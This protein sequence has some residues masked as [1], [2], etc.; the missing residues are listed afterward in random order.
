M[1]SISLRQH[2]ISISFSF[3]PL[4]FINI[5]ILINHSSLPLW[6]SINPIPIIPIIIFEEESASAMFL[7][8]KPITRILPPQL[9]CIQSP[10]RPLSMFLI[11]SPHSLILIPILIELNPKPLLAIIPPISNV[12]RWASPL[13]SLNTAILLSGFFLDPVDTSMGTIFLGFGITKFP[14]VDEGNF[15]LEGHTGLVVKVGLLA[16]GG[17]ILN[18]NLR[19]ENS[20]LLEIPWRKY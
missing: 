6:H 18:R 11:H 15:W 7:I 20:N 16:V 14:V 10:I 13:F 3:M 9:A 12:P 1:V 2:P 8:F 5:S 17:V 19:W 4:S